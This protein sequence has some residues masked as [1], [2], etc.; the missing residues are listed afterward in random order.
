MGAMAKPWLPL[1]LAALAAGCS[2]TSF[3]STWRADGVGR[4]DYAGK[5]VAAVFASEDTA[6]RRSAEDVLARELDA[7][8]ADGVAAYTVI[9]DEVLRDRERARAAMLAAG[10][11]GALVMRVTEKRQEVYSDPGMYTGV[12]YSSFSR[13][14][15]VGWSTAYPARVESDTVV[16]VETLVFRLQD[17]VL[18]WGGMSETFNPT[19]LEP[20]VEE[21]CAAVWEELQD[22]GLVP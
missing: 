2:S 17:D 18:L 20:F 4:I 1:V 11:D 14:C 9:A 6:A 16:S 7:R 22:E 13:N 5:R 15:A 8:G 19:R 3:T 10:F 21:L 12:H